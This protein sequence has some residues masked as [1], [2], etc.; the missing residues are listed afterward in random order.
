MI[1]PIGERFQQTLV[2]LKKVNGQLEREPLQATFFVPMTGQSEE[3]REVKP[4][5][6]RPTLA[7]GSFE[8]T[9]GDAT[10]PAGWYYLR[11]GQSV[12]HSRAPDGQ[13]VLALANRVAGRS[14]QALQSFGVDGQLVKNL[15]VRLQA[16]GNRIRSGRGPSQSARAVI[17]F[18][19][20]DRAAV[21]QSVVRSWTGSF[22]W[23]EVSASVDVPANARLAVIGVG[24]F[25]ATG[26][27][28][29]DHVVIESEPPVEMDE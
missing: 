1:I 13:R 28:L 11:E 10:D 26:E 24:L 4:D 25:G 22:G 29:I 7:N 6:A 2:R 21:G 3:L 23:Q 16:A 12:P 9:I 8:E 14:A 20:E 5:L 19:G 27:L 18:Y 15:H 17:E